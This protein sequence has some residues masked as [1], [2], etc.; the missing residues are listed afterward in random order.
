MTLNGNTLVAIKNGENTLTADTDYTVSGDTVT[1]KKEYLATQAVGSVE[2]TF[3]FSAGEDP[4]LTVTV[5][6]TTP[7]NSTIEPTTATFDKY[8][9][10]TD[11][12]DIAVT[13]TLNGNTLVAIKNGENTLT[14][15]TDYTVSGDTVTIKKE[16]LATQAVGSVELTF[17]FSAGVDPTLTVTVSDST[18]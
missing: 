15:D 11:Y 9:S 12:K 5:S 13:M 14:A 17:D 1:I 3:D 7:Q 10:S 18:P 8:A 2:L 4:T 16:Y 6:D